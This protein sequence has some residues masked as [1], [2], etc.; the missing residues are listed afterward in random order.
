VLDECKEPCMGVGPDPPQEVF[1]LFGG[2]GG[3]I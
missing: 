3:K 1:L 2:M